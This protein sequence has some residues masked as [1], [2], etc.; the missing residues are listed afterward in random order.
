MR[1]LRKA[2]KAYGRLGQTVLI[3]N[4]WQLRFCSCHLSIK[5][6]LYEGGRESEIFQRLMGQAATG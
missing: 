3:L 6:N 2:R 1:M 4:I 5:V